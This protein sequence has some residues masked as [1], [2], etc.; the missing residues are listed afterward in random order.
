MDK[1]R[2]A[3]VTDAWRTWQMRVRRVSAETW[4]LITIAMFAAFMRVVSIGAFSNEY[5]EGV[6]IQS[7]RAMLHHA[8][9]YTTLFYPQPPFFAF[10]IYPFYLLFGQTLPAARL[11]V[12][13]W[14]LLAL[15][16][17]YLI[18]RA[19]AGRWAGNAAVLLLAVDQFF[20]QS[21]Q[22]LQA[23]APSLGMGVLGLG[24]VIE[25]ARRT[26]RARQTLLVAGGVLLGL[27]VS[28]KLF[29]LALLVPAFLYAAAPLFTSMLDREGR[30]QLPRGDWLSMGWREGWPDVA[31][32][33]AGLVA[34]LLLIWGPFFLAGAPI[35]EQVVRYHDVAA[36]QGNP[37]ATLG[38]MAR[39]LTAGNLLRFGLILGF[40]AAV[41]WWRRAWATLPIWLWLA[42]SLVEL[43]RLSPLFAHHLSLFAP[44]L[45]VL[46]S[47]TL[48]LGLASFERRAPS[49]S[50]S[51]VAVTYIVLVVLALSI[52]SQGVV[53]IRDTAASL[54]YTSADQIA[55]AIVLEQL[56]LP[57]DEIVTD[58]PYVATLAGRAVP[59]QLIESSH[60]RVS[61]GYLTTTELQRVILARDTRFVLFASGRLDTVPGFR[62]WVE[63]HFSRVANFAWDNALYEISPSVPAPV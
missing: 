43:F 32:L 4:V 7:L 3:R 46:L 13:V 38:T 42:A 33:A 50:H 54:R 14:S 36:G 31:A 59:P 34:T 44:P 21:S 60:T 40:A 25:S 52:V 51:P 28:T 8:S 57:Q 11:G 39:I 48:V 18:A 26:G 56:T 35:W 62:A 41:A 61:S 30:P 2:V 15:P 49:V 10:A 20:T 22:R 37:L 45:A 29:I 23:E 47:V 53:S 9:L 55:M 1:G 63:A 58:D 19:L 12:A 16:G 27:G 6:Y 17:V 24:L 5:D